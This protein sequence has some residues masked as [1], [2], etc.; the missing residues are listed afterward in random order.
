MK[1]IHQKL[2]ICVCKSWKCKKWIEVGIMDGTIAMG[3]V[4]HSSYTK[5]SFNG[6]YNFKSYVLCELDAV[7]FM[8]FGYLDSLLQGH[9]ELA[10]LCA[11][12]IMLTFF[13]L[14]M[15]VIVFCLWQS[16]FLYSKYS[17]IN[18]K[19]VPNSPFRL[20]LNCCFKCNVL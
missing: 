17:C 6:V 5:L 13:G 8:W 14:P 2:V 3:D 12:L 20:H 19:Y 4:F 16:S 1:G 9:L 7:S 15:F 11:P 18:I 10:K